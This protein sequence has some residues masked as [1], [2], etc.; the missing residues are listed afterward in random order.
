MLTR[1]L[2]YAGVAAPPLFTVVTLTEA[3]ERP[4]YSLS[5]DLISELSL[6]SGGWIQ[7]ANFVITGLLLIA[8]AAGLRASAQ[9][10]PGR[11][12]GPRWV[13]VAGA[14]LLAAG[15]FVTDPG[16]D[17]PP[18]ADPGKSW[19]GTLHSIAGPLVFLALTMTAFTFARSVA[20]PYGIAAGL[21]IATSFVGASVL[22]SLDYAGVWDSPPA[23][24]LES[25]AIYT[26][27]AWLA[28]LAVHT[29]R[30]SREPITSDSSGHLRPTDSA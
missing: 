24:L 12:W 4:G 16:P 30:H 18:A 20:R 15:A 19:H 2:L 7:I 26:G 27:L 21:L 3:T 22:T 1:H 29:L 28:T 10:G 25:V 6:T 23:G 11:V 8:F 13:A 9:G 17:Y 14:A 5:R